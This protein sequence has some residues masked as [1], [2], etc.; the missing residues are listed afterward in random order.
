[1]GICDVVYLVLGV[2]EFCDPQF[3]AGGNAWGVSCDNYRG[4]SLS[5][6]SVAVRCWLL[7]D[8]F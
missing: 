2:C 7:V 5:S 4:L 3:C 1:M 6:E 8:I